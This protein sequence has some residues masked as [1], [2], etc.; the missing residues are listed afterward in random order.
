MRRRLREHEHVHRERCSANKMPA[1]AMGGFVLG[2][3]TTFMLQHHSS[4]WLMAPTTSSVAD[5]RRLSSNEAGQKAAFSNMEA[6]SSHAHHGAST[7]ASHRLMALF[8]LT[9]AMVRQI[10]EGPLLNA[11]L[12]DPIVVWKRASKRAQRYVDESL[13]VNLHREATEWLRGAFV[14]FHRLMYRAHL[15]PLSAWGVG[16]PPPRPY[17]GEDAVVPRLALVLFIKNEA[18]RV[19]KGSVCLQWDN[20]RNLPSQCAS[21]WS[22][23]FVD[24][25]GRLAPV[26]VDRDARVVRSDLRSLAEPAMVGEFGGTFDMIL[27]NFVFEHVSRPLDGARGMY[28]LLKP[29]GIVLFL[30]PFLEK[31][32]LCP[33]AGDYF[34]FTADGARMLFLE[35][36][37][38]VVSTQRIGDSLTTSGYLMGFGLGDFDSRQKQKLLEP[39]DADSVSADDHGQEWLYLGVALVLRRPNASSASRAER[40]A[41]IGTGGGA[42]GVEYPLPPLSKPVALERVEVRP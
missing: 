9:E 20:T 11:E 39:V 32:H 33:P 36:G 41:A 38:D 10:L 24:R 21:K 15:L 2:V 29:G 27:N 22:F 8:G 6:K 13:E 40:F 26:E 30:A 31:F 4:S 28:N 19:P 23:S 3:M 14:R 12:P 7:N 1:V 35:A 16:R 37:Y 42:G 34:R 25:G 18:A 5:S 17:H